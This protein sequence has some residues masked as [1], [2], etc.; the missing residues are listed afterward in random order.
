MAKTLSK[1]TKAVKIV[2]MIH[3]GATWEE[4]AGEF[5]YSAVGEA[6][7]DSAEFSLKEN[8]KGIL[9]LYYL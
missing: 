8:K 9:F 1:E 5:Q 4:V 2:A 7:P 3:A 6:D